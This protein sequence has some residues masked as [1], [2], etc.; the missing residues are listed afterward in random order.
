M[1]TLEDDKE[2]TSS[3]RK[4]NVASAKGIPADTP[5]G[6]PSEGDSDAQ[7]ESLSRQVTNSFKKIL[8]TSETPTSPTRSRSVALAALTIACISVFCTAMDHTVVV[9][10]LPPIITSLMIGPTK[11]D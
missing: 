11:H 4:R 6:L 1:Y 2:T 9:T 8:T 5:T 7:R 10:A 3:L